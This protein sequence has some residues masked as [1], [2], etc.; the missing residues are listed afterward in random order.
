ML[1]KADRNKQRDP[2]KEG[3]SR[4]RKQRRKEG[5]RFP[6]GAQSPN[7]CVPGIERHTVHLYDVDRRPA[8]AAAV[9]AAMGSDWQ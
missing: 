3:L 6:N 4:G 1:P 5:R 9:V 8:A 7:Y 2:L